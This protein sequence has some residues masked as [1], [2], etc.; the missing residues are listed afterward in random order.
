M[1]AKELVS[2][3]YLNAREAVRCGNAA[4]A[5]GNLAAM[6]AIAVKEYGKAA[7][8]N[9][10]EKAK[11]ELFLKRWIEVVRDLDAKGI[12]PFVLECFGVDAASTPVLPPKGRYKKQPPDEFTNT[13]P[14][15]KEPGKPEPEGTPPN[16][17]ISSWIPQDGS[18]GWCA[19]LFEK[20]KSAVTEIR[21]D[22]SFMASAGT[23]FIISEK[24]YLLTNDHV[25][26]SG[27]GNRYYEKLR[28]GLFGGT[29]KYKLEVLYSD[30]P[31]DIALCKFDPTLVKEKFG[32]IKLIDDYARLKQ[33]ADCLVI[34]N[35]F[36]MGLAPCMGIVKFT[37][38]KLGNLV[39]TVPSNPGDSGAPVLNKAGECVGVNKSKTES[40]NGESAQGFSNATPA[41]K[42]KELLDK[43][44][45]AGNITL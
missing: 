20:Y 41:A 13:A 22:G 2:Q 6:L 4:A 36:G 26:Y 31:S 38:D 29:K 28:M 12:T 45:K 30:K 33:G 18:Q 8:G 27:G 43:W 35:P 40:I 21:A 37:R 3:Y 24:G 7:S 34:G 16:A 19:E 23:G 42:V 11:S 25:V 39:Y 44:C 32:T 9:V 10:L 1:N 5:R 14:Q 17:D 15:P